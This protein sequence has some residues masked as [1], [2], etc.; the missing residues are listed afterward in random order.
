CR[1]YEMSIGNGEWKLWR[2]GEPFSQRFTA[3]ITDDGNTITGRWETAEDS[4]NYVPD[5]DLVLRRVV[6]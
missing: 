1:V 4:T 6:D 2:D 5:F 3:T